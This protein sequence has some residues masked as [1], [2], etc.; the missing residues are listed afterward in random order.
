MRNILFYQYVEIADTAALQ[1]SLREL[2]EALGLKGTILIATEGINGCLT[3]EDEPIESF[4]RAL[5]ADE[6]FAEIEF[7]EGITPEHG[8]K[9]IKVKIKPE[10]VSSKTTVSLQN[11]ASYIEPHELK[12]LLDAGEDVVLLDAR[13]NYESAIGKFAG[14]ITPNITVFR[15]FSALPQQLAHLKNKRIVTYCTGGIRCEKASAILKENGFPN[16]QQLHGGI[17]RYGE[18]TGG[19]HWQ[20]TCFVFD[21][22]RAVPVGTV[23]EPIVQ[24]AW[25]SK[26]TNGYF[27]CARYECDAWFVA[28]DECYRGH[29]KTCSSVCETD[30]QNKTVE[31]QVLARSS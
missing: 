6:R 5:Q 25:C 14:A 3:G 11:R 27:N 17:I 31:S 4:K 8:F 9:K 24:C 29:A 2:L 15:D 16:V 30:S 19:A 20:G 10:I 21:T 1:T 23:S 7:K 12:A 22:R 26:P 18:E 28:C 13:N